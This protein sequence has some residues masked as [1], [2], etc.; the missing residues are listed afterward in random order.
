MV[1]HSILRPS[2]L[3]R[4]L[5]FAIQI[6]HRLCRVVDV[7]VEILGRIDDEPGACFRCISHWFLVFEF[8]SL[9]IRPQADIQ[10]AA[11]HTE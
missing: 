4:L 9:P 5:F 6:L 7:V 2:E 3:R 1:H 11:I 8:A 10:A